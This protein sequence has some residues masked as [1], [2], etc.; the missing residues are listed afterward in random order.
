VIV[1][2]FPQNI[3][4]DWT[5]K[6]NIWFEPL[7]K[8]MNIIQVKINPKILSGCLDYI[9]AANSGDMN[10]AIVNFNSISQSISPILRTFDQYSLKRIDYCINFSLNELAPGCSAE[11]M[12]NLIKRSDIPPHYEEWTEYNSIS[13]RMKTKPG[14][15]YLKC[16]SANINCYSK[17]MKFQ[18]Q[19]REDLEKGYPPISS[20]KMDEAQDIIRFEVQCKY[21]K[22]YTLSKQAMDAG[23]FSYNKYQSL[24]APDMCGKIIR[25]YFKKTIGMGDWYTLQEAFKKIAA[26]NFNSQKENRLCSALQEVSQCRSLSKAKAK[27][28][29]N[30][31]DAFK[32]TIKDLS[33]IGIN[34]VTIPK[35]WGVAHIPNLMRAYDYK[36]VEDTQQEL[37]YLNEF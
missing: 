5:I 13:H 7:G 18:E 23:A 22:M 2:P 9:T 8:F 37:E 27:H 26:C 20:K 34:P 24:L 3:G 14:S 19:S 31:L 33:D 30:D 25:E 1:K 35:E 21:R 4:M 15:F 12:M 6:F 36:V 17:Y 10:A 32:R 28:Q 16:H 11:Q 29:G